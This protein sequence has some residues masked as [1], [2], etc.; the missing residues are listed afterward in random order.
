MR[1]APIPEPL[2]AHSHLTAR[3]LP[4]EQA[5]RP[6]P[7][8][9]ARS[10]VCRARRRVLRERGACGAGGVL[11]RHGDA[12]RAGRASKAAGDNMYR[13]EGM[14]DFAQISWAAATVF[15][16]ISD[17]EVGESGGSGSIATMES[18]DNLLS[19]LAANSPAR[20][21]EANHQDLSNLL[22]GFAVGIK[23]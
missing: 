14:R 2:R 21:F 20:I 11:Q 5:N 19:S 23:S 16:R 6:Q 4:L 9:H 10:V 13:L 15:Q 17:V 22:W 3:A 12:R 18:I 8:Q 7:T 1:R